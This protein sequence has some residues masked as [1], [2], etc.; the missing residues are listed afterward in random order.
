M[1]SVTEFYELNLAFIMDS[2]EDLV[3]TLWIDSMAIGSTQK[4]RSFLDGPCVS[5]IQY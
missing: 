1:M 5:T 4:S 2:T 3:Q